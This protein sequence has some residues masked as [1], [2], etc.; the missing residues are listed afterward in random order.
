[1]KIVDSRRV[2]YDSNEEFYTHQARRSKA[3]DNDRLVKGQIPEALQFCILGGKL[4]YTDKH[5]ERADS[6]LHLMLEY[7]TSDAKMGGPLS[8]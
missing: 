5:I 3:H 2:A 1:M 4:K 8:I 7:W 6:I